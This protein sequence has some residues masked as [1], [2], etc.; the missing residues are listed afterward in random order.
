ML[1]IKYET[2]VS[3]IP[4]II[5][6]F[7]LFMFFFIKRN[8][9]AKVLE[10]VKYFVYLLV[11]IIFL[12]VGYG[13]INL[14]IETRQYVVLI[15]PLGWSYLCYQGIKQIIFVT[16][17]VSI[18]KL[19]DFYDLVGLDP[20]MVSNIVKIIAFAL[21]P[22]GSLL[23]TVLTFF[24][25]VPDTA[26][27]PYGMF[28]LIIVGLILLL[29][30]IILFYVFYQIIIKIIFRR[31]GLVAKNKTTV[32]KQPVNIEKI[33]LMIWLLFAFLFVVLFVYLAIADKL[34]S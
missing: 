24:V 21:M 19:V 4:A 31:E 16:F 30:T 32:I 15:L 7:M 20:R 22:L 5:L 23:F 29:V 6:L 3:L 18:R 27:Q 9:L 10:G 28:P 1:E 17:G 25:A 26:N 8:S 2:L 34:N 33:F 11:I 14:A 12:V 13:I